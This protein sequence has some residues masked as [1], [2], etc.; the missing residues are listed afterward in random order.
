V[1]KD[2]EGSEGYA[3]GGCRCGAARI[4]THETPSSVV[5]CRCRDCRRSSGAPVSLFAG[6]LAE[7][8]EWC[9][10][11][12]KVY[13][14]SPGIHRSFCA[15]CGTP[16][17]YEDERLPGEVYLHV[18][19]FDDPEPFEPE[20]HDWMSQKLSWFDIRDDLP[21]YGES[22]TPRWPSEVS[23]SGGAPT[24]LP[25]YPALFEYRAT[26]R[27]SCHIPWKWFV[28]KGTHVQF[29]GSG[30][31]FGSRGKFH[32]CIHVRSEDA[33]FLIDC[34][35]SSLIAMKRFGV[36]PSAIDAVLISH[37]HGDHFGGIPFLVL[38]AQLVSGRTRPLTLAGPPS[39]QSRVH[40]TMEA[41]FP[42]SSQVQRR[43]DLAFV[44]LP[45]GEA[46]DLGA[47]TVTP[48]GVVHPSGAPAYALK[49]E[50]GQKVI[51]YSGDTEWTDSL[52][53]AAR[54]ADLFVCEAYFFEKKVPYHLDYRT[55]MAHRTELGCRR[56]ILTHMS[57]DMLCRLKDVED[58][59]AEDGKSLALW[60]TA[61]LKT[62]ELMSAVEF[63]KQF[64][65]VSLSQIRHLPD[66]KSRGSIEWHNA[67]DAPRWSSRLD[68]PAMRRRL[69][70][71][72]RRLSK[73]FAEKIAAGSE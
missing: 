31:I 46:T 11:E 4:R 68:G 23:R 15:E 18:G 5:Y 64:V 55:L 32:T 3:K 24:L 22:S 19:V 62:T 65:D 67:V 26:H 40:D 60:D 6:Y 73:K 43:F 16:L 54:G 13:E 52:L 25:S 37:L 72:S 66:I 12:Q 51:S 17:S 38:D 63:G 20:V 48:Y 9:R 30:D 57:E 36:D 70:P 61:F 49:V 58:E 21:R 47:L 1:K 2:I 50:C 10:G 27:P 8:V 45:E 44:E 33:T 53:Q 42:G 28:M 41:L 59:W 71:K 34:G 39:L 69:T 14:P 29:L 56:L 7:Q 35:A